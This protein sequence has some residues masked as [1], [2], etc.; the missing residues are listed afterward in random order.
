MSRN[1]KKN[2]DRQK[3]EAYIKKLDPLSFARFQA[4]LGA[5]LGLV[6][7]VIY[8]FGGFIIDA[9]VTLGWVATTET[10]GLSYGTVIAFGALIGMPLIGAVMG[11]LAGLISAVLYNAYARWFGGVEVDFER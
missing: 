2:K 10:P 7:G 6:A 9:L 4:L 5:L 8:S 11:L 1:I 3:V